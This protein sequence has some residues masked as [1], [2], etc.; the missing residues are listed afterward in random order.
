MEFEQLPEE[1]VDEVQIFPA[2]WESFGALLGL[3]EPLEQVGDVI[4]KRA[5][6]L[7]CGGFADKVGDQQAHQQLALDGR[8]P[9]RSLR[10]VPQC[11][12]ALL[13]E[14]VDGSLLRAS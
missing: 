5:D 12:N 13:R 1:A 10:P 4:A 11:I 7:P 2:V 6:P 14:R 3:L 9:N 8:D